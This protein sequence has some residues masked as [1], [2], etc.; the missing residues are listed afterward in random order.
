MVDATPPESRVL[1]HVERE[2]GD[3][4]SILSTDL[5]A[6]GSQL[7]GKSR[8]S[9]F[10]SIIVPVMVTLVT[11]ASTSLFQYISWKNS[12][13]LQGVSEEAASASK[14]YDRA[15]S[16]IEKRYYATYLFQVA[17]KTIANRKISDTQ[18]S[19]YDIALQQRRFDGFYAQLASWNQNYNQLL[20]DISYDL[21]RPIFPKFPEKPH[22]TRSET[23]TIWTET[24]YQ[25][26][27]E[28]MNKIRCKIDSL[29]EEIRSNGLDQLALTYHFAVIN[30]CFAS[31]LNDF[32]TIKDEVLSN[33]DRV[34]SSEEFEKADTELDGVRSMLNEFRCYALIRIHFLTARK[35]RTI[36]F[37]A[38]TS[39]EK[40]LIDDHRRDTAIKCK[41][42]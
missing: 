42:N 20:N 13:K 29:P 22:Q 37:A 38:L 9:I 14:T 6:I 30:K 10:N 11:L 19:Q 31:A 15:A 23:N 36:V 41:P 25:I 5:E 3:R 27:K 12:I 1:I 34:I 40:Q 17:V 24:A 18:L 8:F 35:D 16:E 21:D 32:A 7:R 39:Q 4:Y 33:K 28:K 26:T 2:E